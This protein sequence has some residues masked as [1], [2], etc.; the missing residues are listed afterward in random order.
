VRKREKRVVLIFSSFRCFFGDDTVRGVEGDVELPLQS[1]LYNSAKK[2]KT[3]PLRQASSLGHGD[4]ELVGETDNHDIS[5]N[6][7]Y[8]AGS[9]LCGRGVLRIDGTGSL[10]Y[11]W[12][13]GCRCWEGGDGNNLCFQGS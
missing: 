8:E 10:H 11:Y 13:G 9:S 12:R 1:C 3:Y 6:I 4:E 7:F 5:G 2:R